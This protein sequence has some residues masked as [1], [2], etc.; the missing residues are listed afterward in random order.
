[1]TTTSIEPTSLYR[2]LTSYI[3]GLWDRREFAWYL[4]LG[5]LRAQ[6]SSTV[7]GIVWYVLNPLLLA[8]VYFFV[9]GFII[10]GSRRGDPAFLAYLVSG[11]FVFHFTSRTMMGGARTITGNSKIMVNLRFPR[12]LL[13]IASIIESGIGFLVSIAAFFLIIL[14]IA[15][16][17]PGAM[18]LW[19]FPIFIAQIIMNV[20][21]TALSA[22]LTVPF[23]D[24]GNLLPYLTRIWLYLSPII[25]TFDRIDEAPAWVTRLV[26]LNP[27]FYFLNVYRG[28]LLGTPFAIQDLA[29]AYLF[30]VVIAAIG[31]TSFVRFEGKLVQ[32]L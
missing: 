14:P 18:F 13:P 15:R 12:L 5:N 25:W 19:F 22:R 23:R 3:L 10:T 26:H 24:I 17:W 1:M 8:G 30:A 16:I 28:A 31:I 2:R 21:L 7:F 32:Y 11:M 29:I 4:A 27:M 20:G 6:N 9:F